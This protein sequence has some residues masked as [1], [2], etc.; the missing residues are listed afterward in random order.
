MT[1][2]FGLIAFAWMLLT[3]GPLATRAG[4]HPVQQFIVLC[5]MLIIYLAVVFRFAFNQ[6]GT[7]VVLWVGYIIFCGLITSFSLFLLFEFVPSLRDLLNLKSFRYYAAKGIYADDPDLVFIKKDPSR[8]YRG[9]LPDRADGTTSQGVPYIASFTVDGF[10]PNSSEPPYDIALIGDS[11]IEIGVNDQSTLSEKIKEKSGLSTFNLG[12]GWYGPHQYLKLAEKYLPEIK[13]TYAFF[14]FFAG[15]D[16]RDIKAYEN[17]KRTGSYYFYH[18]NT[19]PNILMGY[20]KILTDAYYVGIRKMATL[21]ANIESRMKG[22]DSLHPVMS[23]VQVGD[24][25]VPMRFWYIDEQYRTDL[26]PSTPVWKKLRSILQAFKTFCLE[27]HVIPVVVY[28][29]SKLEV[30]DDQIIRNG[31]YFER[32]FKRLYKDP[33][34]KSRAIEALTNTLDIQLIN[35][36]HAF[37]QEARK[38]RQLFYPVNSHWNTSGIELAAE[39]I[40]ASLASSQPRSGEI[41]AQ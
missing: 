14:C 10:R 36:L 1:A 37:E 39:L 35:L 6:S 23:I 33:Y 18:S 21:S 9:F 31:H 8:K 13:P 30:Y 40:I 12:L 38:G 16:I 11:F 41:K 22:I 34:V 20:L 2:A 15:N 7:H 27:H 26:L 19:L 4:I 3:A 29:P 24:K 28:I 5:L 25:E 32:Q 17:W